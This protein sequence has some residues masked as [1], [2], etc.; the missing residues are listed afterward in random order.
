MSVWHQFI[1]GKTSGKTMGNDVSLLNDP[2]PQSTR[3]LSVPDS[4]MQDNVLFKAV[5]GLYAV[6]F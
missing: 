5:N 6:Q 2:P 4:I 1:N 3:F